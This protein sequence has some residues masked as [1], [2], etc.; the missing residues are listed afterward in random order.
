MCF[1]CKMCGFILPKILSVSHVPGCGVTDHLASI[2]R[3]HQ[4]GVIPEV[5]E[6]LV[7]THRL[8]E[9]LCFLEK[10]NLI[11]TLKFFKL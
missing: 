4:H 10:P 3:L 6:H 7:K 2:V 9:L 8:E 11:P 1:L 5:R